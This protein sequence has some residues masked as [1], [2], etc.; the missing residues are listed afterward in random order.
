LNGE[1][2]VSAPARDSLKG[3]VLPTCARR[4]VGIGH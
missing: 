2:C 4:K 1:T 3:K